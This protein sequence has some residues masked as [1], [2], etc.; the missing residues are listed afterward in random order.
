M[1]S[2]ICSVFLGKWDALQAEEEVYVKM[3]EQYGM[4]HRQE[5][6]KTAQKKLFLQWDVHCRNDFFKH[7]LENLKITEKCILR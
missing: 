6:Q 7:A 1:S 4:E 3:M 5:K 2:Y